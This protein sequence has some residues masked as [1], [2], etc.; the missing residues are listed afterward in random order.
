MPRRKG[1]PGQP[2]TGVEQETAALYIQKGE[3]VAVAR[4][5]GVD[6][7][8]TNQT[9]MTAAEKLDLDEFQEHANKKF[10]V[11]T[12]KLLD[13]THDLLDTRLDM[14]YDVEQLKKEDISKL[15]RVIYDLK[16]SL[17]GTVNFIQLIAEKRYEAQLSPQDLEHEAYSLL[18]EKYSLTVEE[19][20]ARLQARK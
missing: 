6:K 19:V 20:K 5:R 15:S 1:K 8:A 9:L 7:A 10:M 17:Q 3:Q 12:W 16:R 13:K 14:L 2:L 11:K 4:A 18:A